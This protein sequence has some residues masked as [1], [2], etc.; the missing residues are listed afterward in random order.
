MIS[1]SHDC[2]QHLCMKALGGGGPC[3]EVGGHAEGSKVGLELAGQ[4][5]PDSRLI[6]PIVEANLLD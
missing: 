2:Y 4:G 6:G 3:W 1:S 5:L